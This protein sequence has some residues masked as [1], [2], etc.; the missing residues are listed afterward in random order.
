MTQAHESP[1]VRNPYNVWLWLG[2]NLYS[3]YSIMAVP[4]F[5]VLAAA[6][7]GYISY[8]RNKNR[9]GSAAKGIYT[10]CSQRPGGMYEPTT[11]PLAMN[12]RRRGGWL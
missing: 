9:K 2:D 11:V 5:V 1:V 8:R 12:E 6:L 10:P 3:R 4:V 7:I